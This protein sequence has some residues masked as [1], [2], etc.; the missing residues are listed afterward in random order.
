MPHCDSL[1][2]SW[3]NY[4]LTP[5]TSTCKT[6][7]ECLPNLFQPVKLTPTYPDI[8]LT[9]QVWAPDWYRLQ[10]RGESGN[11]VSNN[12]FKTVFPTVLS[13]NQYTRPFLSERISSSKKFPY[14][15][16]YS[17]IHVQCN[18][19]RM[20]TKRKTHVQIIQIYGI[21]AHMALL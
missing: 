10:N 3:T 7:L 18:F 9:H 8:S 17:H 6:L 21:D 15:F 13:E 16:W 4:T 11:Q 1:Y 14:P 12:D 2:W 20:F 5:N 19:I